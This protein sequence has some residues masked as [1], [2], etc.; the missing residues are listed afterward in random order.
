MAAKQ[1]PTKETE[2]KKQNRP[3]VIER[4][5][6]LSPPVALEVS[7]PAT[8]AAL[9]PADDYLLHGSEGIF[10]QGTVENQVARMNDP[11]L[12]DG[13]RQFM[14]DQVGRRQGN[15]HLQ[16]VIGSI[17]AKQTNGNGHHASDTPANSA[18]LSE[19]TVAEDGAEGFGFSSPPSLAAAGE[20]PADAPN[21]TPA[22]VFRTTLHSPRKAPNLPIQRQLTL[23]EPDDLY[24]QEADQVAD[25]VLRMP[26]YGPATPPDDDNGSTTSG[27][28]VISRLQ[29]GNEA[30]TELSPEV[31]SQVEH[32][33][34]GG[35]PLPETERGFF[36]ARLDADLSDVRIHTDEQAAQTA[37]DLNARAYTIGPDIAFNAGEYQP[38]TNEGRHLLAHELTHVMQQGAASEIQ[39]QEEEAE[40]DLPTEEE[41]A[42]ALAL[43]EAAKG[44]ASVA[45]DASESQKGEAQGESEAKKAEGEG[46]KQ[47]AQSSQAQGPVNK[48]AGKA[49]D[50]TVAEQ[51]TQTKAEKEAQQAST[52]ENAQIAAQEVSAA[53]APSSAA[54]PAPVGG[55]LNGSGPGQGTGAGLEGATAAAEAKLE[56]AMQEAETAPD[57]SPE[58][59]A[60]DPAYQSVE[61]V[62]EQVKEAEKVHG[63]A[64]GEAD[65][66]QAAAESPA[67]EIEGQAQAGQVGE[68]EQA[69]TP[70]FDA[71]GFKAQLMERIEALMP[72]TA[73]D[74]DSFKE[75]GDM[76]G[77]KGEMQGQVAKEKETS[78]GPLEQKSQEAPD[79]SS[80]EPKPVTPLE[81]GEPGA[82]PENIGAEQAVPK[83]KGQGEIETP[84]QESGQALDQ[85][86]ADAEITEEQL[87]NSNEPEF[88][89][90]LEA[91]NEAKT[92]VAEAPGTY[93]QAEQAQLGQAEAEA[94]AVA[95]EQLQSMHGTRSGTLGQIDGQQSETKSEDERKREEIANHINEIY[96][97][98]KAEVETI[99]NNLDG[100]VEAAFDAGAEA[101]K[102]SFENYVD[103][104]TEAFKQ[105]EYGGLLGWAE[106]EIDMFFSP[107]PE[108]NA[109]I[110]QGRDHYLSEMDAV[111][112]QVISIISTR[113]A[114]A[115]AAIANGKQR[116]Q[117]YVNQLPEDLQAIGQEAADAIQSR[118]DA[119]EEQIDAKQNELIDTLAN[120]YKE[121][122]EAL[123]AQIEEMKEANKSVLE[124]AIDA[125]AGV[126]KTIIELK[127]LLMNALSNAADAVMMILK[128]PI[129]FV[130]NLISAV[131]QG[132][133]NFVSNIAT[134]LQT[135]FVEWLTGT[136]G[137]AGI[138]MPED[139]FSLEGVLDLVLQ[140]LGLTWENFRARAVGIFGE[141]IVAALET[142]FEIFM[143]LKDE[144]LIGV[145][146]WVQ[147]QLAN[148]QDQVIEGIKEMLITEVIE[149]G[150]K[151][152]IGILGG[153]AGA[154]IKA[155][156]AIYDIVMWFIN[157]AQ[158]LASLVQSISES[159]VAIASG[160]LDSAA[161]FIEKSLADF[162]PT[163]IGFLASLLGLGDLAQKV[164]KIIDR[165]Q[166]PVNS[167]I[168]YVLNM[169]KEFV[170]KI[171]KMLGFGGE[172]GGEGEIGEELSFSDES[173]E[174]H[175]QWVQVEGSQ[176][177]LMVA[178]EEMSVLDQLAAWEAD[179]NKLP[180]TLKANAQQLLSQVLNILN[181]AEGHA[182]YLANMKASVK[183][184]DD[185]D[186][187]SD[188]QRS[189]AAKQNALVP[190]LGQLFEIFNNEETVDL[191][192]IEDY[193]PSFRQSTKEEFAK[194][195]PD[196]H[197]PGT[198]NL[199]PGINRVHGIGYE[200]IRSGIFA[201][202]SG[203]PLYEAAGILSGKGYE[204]EEPL[205][206]QTII[207]ATKAYLRDQHDDIDNLAPGG[208]AGNKSAGGTIPH[209]NN[210]IDEA[211]ASGDEDALLNSLEEYQEA[212]TDQAVTNKKHQPILDKLIDARIDQ[213]LTHQKENEENEE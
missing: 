178:S 37:Q 146:E 154:F 22:T 125:V 50:Q 142:G 188:E 4:T 82:V 27:Q 65:E 115:K 92:T 207:E 120:K 63:P 5:R 147:D 138:Q 145:W 38:G 86:M 204:P 107:P 70:A 100:E 159:I 48:E 189:L 148:L 8:G 45:Q 113:L 198:T 171:A 28:P 90:A 161:Q 205:S 170:M 84:L 26:A 89:G 36:E 101:A 135:G 202:I 152:L 29:A 143:I 106:W 179:V 79:T 182:D 164:R 122:L 25:T 136:M 83:P 141:T 201:Q 10:T 102:I 9:S 114:E 77:L 169:I 132:L 19:L 163:A 127:N 72:Q 196:A 41:K 190:I 34:G 166:E 17:Q 80:V 66:A 1:D 56:T 108:L 51:A 144:G 111:I 212:S 172:G 131:T 31:E 81:P 103:A 167:A 162:V 124:R 180:E 15:L 30:T 76:N 126:I 33:Q 95:Q 192:T 32:M 47:E 187:I 112:D 39:R 181:D 193:R 14:A 16:R 168:D 24:E 91:K 186:N 13:D 116:I 174:S 149:A 175:R 53:P 213:F 210:R 194:R 177:T 54:A 184:I 121:N 140:I 151:W 134:H 183:T 109:I 20:P 85:Q 68:M 11:R 99:L 130:G 200:V 155:A 2:T 150:I 206:N 93:R 173:G 208:E 67:S 60:E 96:E 203:K 119:L 185:G 88:Q 209:I 160:S 211:I 35:A 74:A 157:N 158:R 49:K 123:D 61:N 43:A 195:F 199:K 75:D 137:E 139:I 42:E 97:E 71:A 58:T 117:D 18:S 73:E 23:N 57:K 153:P 98:T 78:Q 128:D 21:A 105:R 165:I 6:V 62:T 7:P 94:A 59:P 191:S 52:Q 87:E 40:S 156:M 3:E 176:A 197:I 118:F 133:E 110:D 44:E 104:E 46:P 12:S 55:G 129:G 69:E 64:Q